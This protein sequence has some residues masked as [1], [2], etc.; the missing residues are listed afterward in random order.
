MRHNL[1]CKY[2]LASWNSWFL[3][4]K[5]DVGSVL[6]VISIP[7]SVKATSSE[8]A[9]VAGRRGPKARVLP[10]QAGRGRALLAFNVQTLTSLVARKRENE[11]CIEKNN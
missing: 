3:L 7:E 1:Y 9:T 6:N 2:I 10:A 11:L 4:S 5:L 8:C